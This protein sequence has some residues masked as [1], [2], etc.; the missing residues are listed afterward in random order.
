MS[1]DTERSIEF[2]VPVDPQLPER[3]PP[4]APVSEVQAMRY[5]S[6]ITFD[7]DNVERFV[8]QPLVEACRVLMDQNITT[9]LTSA[10]QEDV[11]RGSP[12]VI[13]IDYEALTKENRRMAQAVGR[14]TRDERIHH[15]GRLGI[16][17]H[18]RGTVPPAADIRTAIKKAGL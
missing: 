7:R 6:C 4:D 2:A 11:E 13:F 10:N 9:T 5:I 8:E 3:R 12:A 15:R 17:R 14:L 18:H 1:P 16:C